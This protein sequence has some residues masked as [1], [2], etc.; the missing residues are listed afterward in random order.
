MSEM[1]LGFHRVDL[2]N[3][4]QYEPEFLDQLL[5]VYCDQQRIC[6]EQLNR[7]G[8]KYGQKMPS[9]EDLELYQFLDYHHNELE[10]R[11]RYITNEVS[12]L[13]A[14]LHMDGIRLS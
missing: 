11:I 6:A 2:G 9:G 3:L 7:L 5:G 4:S 13:K 14:E 12:G 1:A 8:D 10:L